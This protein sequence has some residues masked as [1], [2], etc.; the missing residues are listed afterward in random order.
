MSAGVSVFGKE[1]WIWMSRKMIASPYVIVW[2]DVIPRPGSLG[3]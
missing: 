3:V 2:E 1:F